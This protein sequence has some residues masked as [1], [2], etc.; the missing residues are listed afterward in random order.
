MNDI[1]FDEY[2]KRKGIGDLL[3]VNEKDSKRFRFYRRRKE[4]DDC[5]MVEFCSDSNNYHCYW[6]HNIS[7]RK[8]IDVS[9]VTFPDDSHKEWKRISFD[10]LL[11]YNLPQIV[12]R[13]E[14]Y[15]SSNKE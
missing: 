12:K 10:P 13:I 15:I 4:W 3:F 14:D 6:G 8:E 1:E 9:F 7:D 11:A 2:V 5:Y